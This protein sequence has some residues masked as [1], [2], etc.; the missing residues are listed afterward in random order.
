MIPLSMDKLIEVKNYE[1]TADSRVIAEGFMSSNKSILNLIRSHKRGLKK[2]GKVTFEKAPTKNGQIQSFA[3]LNE[4]QTLLLLTYTRS[5]EATDGFR[6]QLIREFCEQ[7]EALKRKE[8]VRLAGIETRKSLMETV[9]N[10]GENERMHGKGYSNYTRM[11]YEICGLTEKY[12]EY[13][14]TMKARG[15]KA[16]DF[17]GTLSPAELK[18]VKLAESLTK[19]LLELEKQYS[20]IKDT[21]KPLFEKKE[22]L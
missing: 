6:E 8:V 15:L 19:P 20:E 18:R 11:I 22:I 7:R 5:N 4:P 12:K 3:R 16:N 13:K 14:A 1:A 21:L 17:R 2:F 9:G 10:C